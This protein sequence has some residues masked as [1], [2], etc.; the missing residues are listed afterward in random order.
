MELTLRDQRMLDMQI[1]KNRSPVDVAD[2][3]GLD[4]GYVVSRTKELLASEDVYDILEQRQMS[5]YRLKSLYAQAKE[6]LDSGFIDRKTWPSA[7]TAIT[8]L[9]ETTYKIQQDQEAKLTEERLQLTEAQGRILV[10]AVQLAYERARLALE[11]EYPNVD[12]DVLDVAFYD[13][14]KEVTSA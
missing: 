2:E 10:Q 6:L 14:L 8:S 13:G 7:V 11:R 12:T 1:E 5:L 4:V 3:L 9:I